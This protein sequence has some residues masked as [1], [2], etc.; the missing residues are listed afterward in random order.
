VPNGYSP[1]TI[2]VSGG[3]EITLPL[4]ALYMQ[5]DVGASGSASNAP[6]PAFTIADVYNQCGQFSHYGVSANVSTAA[7]I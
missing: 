5:M 2:D 6:F 4:G 1:S 3:N 7:M